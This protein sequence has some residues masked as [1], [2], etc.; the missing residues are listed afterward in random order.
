MRIDQIA[1]Y[2][3][4]LGFAVM[5][6]TQDHALASETAPTGHRSHTGARGI[7]SISVSPPSAALGSEITIDVTPQTAELTLDDATAEVVWTGI[8]DPVVGS[9]TPIFSA[10]YS[11]AEVV[12]V[13]PW[14]AKIV[15]GGGVL[16]GVPNID[17]VDSAGVLSGTLRMI[18]DPVCASDLNNSGAVNTADLGTMIGIFG[19]TGPGLPADLNGDEVVDT[20]D[21]GILISQFGTTCWINGTVNLT[22]ET[23]AGHWIGVVYPDGI[24]GIDPPELG[25]EPAELPIYLLSMAPDPLSPTEEQL[26]TSSSMHLSAVLRIDENASSIIAAPSTVLVDLI[27]FSAVGIETDRVEDVL[28]TQIIGDG[29]PNNITY[30]SDLSTPILLVDHTINKAAFPGFVLLIADVDG[31]AVIAPSN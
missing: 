1:V 24:G 8:F 28:L 12:V 22:P 2:A 20:A 21:L 13:S 7:P 5:A 19:Q 29:D 16:S 14:Q 30:G 17:S 26:N 31:S 11:A 25:S 4:G 23:D 15:F 10:T 6:G 27:A 9:N 3:V 18:R